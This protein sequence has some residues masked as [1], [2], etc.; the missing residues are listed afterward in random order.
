MRVDFRIS[1]WF[2]M[3]FELRVGCGE[4][5]SGEKTKCVRI[6]MRFLFLL[7][8]DLLK[9]PKKKKKLKGP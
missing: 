4:N 8:L 5:V 6:C 2:W 3:M 1:N 7:N 9:K